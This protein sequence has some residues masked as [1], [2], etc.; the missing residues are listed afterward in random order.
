M[1]VHVCVYRYVWVCICWYRCLCVSRIGDHLE[2]N[3]PSLDTLILTGNNIQELGD[4]DQLSSVTTLTT[5]RYLIVSRLLS[6][7]K[8]FQQLPSVDSCICIKVQHWVHCYLWFSWKL[9]LEF[10]V[11][12]PWE[13][14]ADDLVVI[15]ETENNLW[16][17]SGT[18]RVSRYQ[19]KHS[20]TYTHRGHQSSLICFI[21]LLRCTVVPDKIHR[22]VKRLCVYVC[23]RVSWYQE[24]HSPTHTY[25]GH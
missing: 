14:Y 25:R 24:K 13:L 23:T 2:A 11:T 7:F 12:L 6:S 9:Y 18:T 22:G 17:L 5:L 10:K 20:L 16:I 3:L 8:R 1:C 19:K 4:L 15:A 21:H